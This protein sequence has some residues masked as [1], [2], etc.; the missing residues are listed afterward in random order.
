VNHWKLNKNRK[1]QLSPAE[2]LIKKTPSHQLEK[3]F[4]KLLT[5]DSEKSFEPVV[6]TE[7]Q[8]TKKLTTM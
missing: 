5:P 1:W 2:Q 3:A 8:R 4:Y 6:P 7:Q